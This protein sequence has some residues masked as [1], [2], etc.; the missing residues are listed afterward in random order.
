VTRV[1]FLED[2]VF[3]SLPAD[4][5]PCDYSRPAAQRFVPLDAGALH[6][7]FSGQQRK[8]RETIGI[9][10]AFA[11]QPRRIHFANFRAYA[12]TQLGCIHGLDSSETAAPLAQSLPKFGTIPPERGHDTYTGYC[13]PAVFHG[14]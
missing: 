2:P 4:A 8:L 7:F 11:G 14:T 12:K 5:R 6:G 9:L 1:N 10:R 13:D 3:G